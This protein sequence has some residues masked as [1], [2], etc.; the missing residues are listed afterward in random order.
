MCSDKSWDNCCSYKSSN[1]AFLFSLKCHAG[2]S[3]TKMKLIS[4]HK[5]DAVYCSSSYGPT[6]GGGHDL[7]IG[8]SFCGSTK[9]T[10]YIN[11]GYTYELPS[12]TSNTFLTGKHGPGSPFEV[13]EVEV[14]HV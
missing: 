10:G 12:G 8:Y 11:L 14:F 1:E 3:P 7:R 6:F 2:V 5:S 4:G 13:A 9:K